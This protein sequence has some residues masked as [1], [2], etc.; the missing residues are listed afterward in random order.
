MAARKTI[1]TKTEPWPERTRNRIRTSMLLNRLEKFVEGKLELS[2]AQV[3]AGLGL[4]KKTV[5]DLSSV[6]HSGEMKQIH[7]ITGEPMSNDDW[8]AT[9]CVG[10]AAGSAESTH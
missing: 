8:E 5:P 2:P 10:P 6:E 7:T 3:T 9:Y 1:G 4:L